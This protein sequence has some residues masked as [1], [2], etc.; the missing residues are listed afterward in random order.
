MNVCLL[1][2]VASLWIHAEVETKNNL[3]KYRENFI[4]STKWIT[5]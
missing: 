4:N 1:I 3:Y 5:F 2:S